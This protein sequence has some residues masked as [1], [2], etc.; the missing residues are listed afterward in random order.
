M[1]FLKGLA[2]KYLIE[3]WTSAWKFISMW[4][5]AI[6]GAAPQLYNLAI[7]HNLYSADSV[8]LAIA[9]FISL[10]AFLGSAGRVVKQQMLADKTQ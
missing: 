5:Y 9:N 8:P 6:I 3:D 4:I 2:D 10:M 1:S 7:Q